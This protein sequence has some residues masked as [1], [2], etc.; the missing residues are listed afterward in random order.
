MRE[1]QTDEGRERWTD[2][3]QPT[4]RKRERHIDRGRDGWT[5]GQTNQERLSRK[6]K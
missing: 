2:T 4:E 1:R 6:E 5:N 3:D